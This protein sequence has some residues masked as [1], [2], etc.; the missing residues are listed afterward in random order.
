MGQIKKTS[1]LLLLL[2]VKQFLL[3]TTPV[4]SISGPDNQLTVSV[5]IDNGKPFY[6]V[7]YKGKEVI[8]NSPLGMITNIGD[9]SENM[10]F[11]AR[12]T[13]EIDE[14]YTLNRIKKSRV[15]YQANECVFS[16]E[17]Q[18]N[19]S[20][21]IIFRVG[22]NDLAFRYALP[23]YGETACCTIEK[24][25]TGFN[26]PA[27]T[28][29]FLTP[30]STPMSFWKRTK[31]SYEEKYIAD[32]P[33]GT[34]SQYGLGYTFPG[35]FR[36]DNNWVLVSETGV[37]SSYCASRLSE[38]T[39]DG[40]FTIAFPDERENNGIGNSCPSIALPGVTPWRTITV[41]D[42]LK[43][44][45]ETTI[46]FDVVKP[47]Y[48]PSVDYKFGRSTWS[49]IMWQDESMNYDDQV[50]YIDLAAILGYE[51]ILIDALW[52]TKIGYERIPEL[53][54]YAQSKG[55]DVF[56]WYNSNGYWNDAPQ[57]PKHKMDTSIARKKEM[58]WLK[59]LDIKGLKVD[60]FGGDKQQ[61]MQLY[62]DILSDANEYGLMI[63][64][65]GATIPR[66]WE[67]MYP[68][69]VGSEA[70]LASESLIF[71]QETCDNE[72]Y[73]ACFHPF[74]RNAIGSMEFGPV[75]LNKRFNRTN[76]GGPIRR[77]TDIFQIATS[78][79]FQNPVQL[80]AIAP[81]NLTD[82]P[83]LV[84]DF[85]SGVPTTWDETVFIDGYPGKYCVLA[86][87]HGEK[88]YVAGI[89]AQKEVC[90]IKMRLPMLEGQTFVK[91][92]DDQDRKAHSKTMRLK[93][94]E[95]I[96]L[97]IQPEGGIVLATFHN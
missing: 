63:I 21:D 78:V 18:K 23:E 94:G 32:E 43:P 91:Y 58:K 28:T 5:C 1:L 64:F 68:N 71:M 61:T 60:F 57:G 51:Y 96:I 4:A 46:P 31:P 80:F 86:R 22:N 84:I 24:E 69:Y 20:I 17:N 7:H 2:F 11:I 42:N 41:G 74:I 15:H 36:V 8:E 6:S 85:M 67:R 83:R 55:V 14:I 52:D 33:L 25:V 66:G 87:R 16:F 56:L 9:F 12:K 10:K 50:K 34:P 93:K 37:S 29:T 81:N 72:A 26:F 44:I 97:E 76:D 79:L 82:A 73:N 27:S 49:W 77:T 70:V 13:S 53:I 59:S 30:Q 47:L 75:L 38:G 45:V 35:L 48:E 62:E 19:Q 90:T 92:Y 89:N 88:W 39:K 65:H 95:E 40:L 3:A 54:R